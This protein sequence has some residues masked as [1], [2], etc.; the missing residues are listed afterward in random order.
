M[1]TMLVFI[2]VFRTRRMELDRRHL[3][4]QQLFFDKA[5]LIPIRIS[6]FERYRDVQQ[7]HCFAV[8]D[9]FMYRADHCQLPACCRTNHQLRMHS[10]FFQCLSLCFAY[11]FHLICLSS[12]S[13]RAWPDAKS[14]LRASLR[15]P[16]PGFHLS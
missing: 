7:V 9:V 8:F 13:C 3:V 14:C 16:F 1:Q 11:A 6:V 5:H 2:N 12:L 15:F 4:S 10:E